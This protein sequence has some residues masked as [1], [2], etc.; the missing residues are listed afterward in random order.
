MPPCKGPY[1][2]EAKKKGDGGGLEIC[3]V[4]ADSIG[5]KQ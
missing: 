4:V 5:L 1:I 2:Y 3:Y